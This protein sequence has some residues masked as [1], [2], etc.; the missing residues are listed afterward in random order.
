MAAL[1]AAD[2]PAPRSN[3]QRPRPW[4]AEVGKAWWLLC[5]ASP[6]ASG[7]SQARLRDSSPVANGRRPKKW[8]SELMLKV[9]VVQDEHPHG[10]APQQA[11]QPARERAAVSATPEAERDAPGRPTTQSGKVRSMKR[12]SRS[13]SRSLA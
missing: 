2:E 5:H 3:C 1:E 4:R 10:A 11:G 9:D 6:K 12:R 8:Q 7:A 13:A